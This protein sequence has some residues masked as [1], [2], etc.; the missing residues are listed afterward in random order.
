MISDVNNLNIGYLCSDYE[1]LPIPYTESPAPDINMRPINA[2]EGL[3][4]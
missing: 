4:V 1:T 2:H 3:D